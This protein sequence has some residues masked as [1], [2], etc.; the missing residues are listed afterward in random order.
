[1]ASGHC[2]HHILPAWSNP[3]VSLMVAPS[4]HRLGQ[5]LS[6]AQRQGYS[7]GQEAPGA[8]GQSQAGE[9]ADDQV[10]DE[11]QEVGEPPGRRGRAVMGSPGPLSHAC[12]TLCDTNCPQPA[13]KQ[14]R[15]GAPLPPNGKSPACWADS[16]LGL[17]WLHP[18]FCL[19][20]GATL[21]TPAE[22]LSTVPRTFLNG[23][24]ATSAPCTLSASIRAWAEEQE[25]RLM[26]AKKGTS[27]SDY[28]G[29]SFNSHM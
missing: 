22:C 27:P 12:L 8:L 28:F 10:Q 6:Q 11:E 4:P 5:L 20:E 9:E 16:S 17:W 25:R 2:P 24:C 7:R 13:A 14:T 21:P 29:P 19:D 23:T 26:Q 18:S 1:M 15:Q 3:Q